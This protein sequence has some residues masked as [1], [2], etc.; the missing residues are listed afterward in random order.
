[1]FVNYWLKGYSVGD[2]HFHFF[3]RL[4]SLFYD[5]ISSIF[6]AMSRV[7][8]WKI[9]ENGGGISINPESSTEICPALCNS[10][11]SWLT[12]TYRIREYPVISGNTYPGKLIFGLF[13]EISGFRPISTFTK[14]RVT[15]NP[16][17]WGFLHSIYGLIII[18]NQKYLLVNQNWNLQ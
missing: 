2:P 13:Q 6:K 1:M 15:K 3:E 5:S 18:I 16:R 12:M 9:A 10:D 17:M 8:W 14:R 4:Q 7:N 11:H